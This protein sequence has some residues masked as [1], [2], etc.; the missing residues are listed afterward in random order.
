[1]KVTIFGKTGQLARSLADSKPATVKATFLS[2]ND[3]ELQDTAMIRSI[4]SRERPHFVVNAAAYTAVDH[5]EKDSDAAM[6]INATAP[7]VMAK[8]V[9]E[10]AAKL[11]H[12]STDF[13]FEGLNHV[14]YKPEDETV[15]ISL[16][17]KSKLTGEIEVMNLAAEAAMII[18]TAWLYSEYSNN[19]LRTMLR[20]MNER[21][22]LSVVDDQR[23][24]PTY[25]NG[26]A[27]IIWQII[28][29]ERLKSG[30]YHWTDGADISWYEFAQHIQKEALKIELIERAIPILAISSKQY[31]TLARRP[32]YSVLDTTSLTDLLSRKSDDWHLNLRLALHRIA[33]RI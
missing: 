5:A 6:A 8:W 15:P 31:P 24:S 25:A 29:E 7:G 17:G 22:S 26:L 2:R 19:F 18:R 3:C 9:T 12:I 1:M 27:Q 23:G 28:T 32:P 14:P 10:H 33:D 13:V 11:I 20:L 21:D 4:L 16:Y 30:I